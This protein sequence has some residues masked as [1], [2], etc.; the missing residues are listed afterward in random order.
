MR[1]ALHPVLWL[2]PCLLAIVSGAAAPGHAE[3][4]E[5]N[6]VV[7]VT[8][9]PHS[10]HR[11][12]D[13]AENVYA[14]TYRDTYDYADALVILTYESSPDTTFAGHLSA[15]N[16][17]PNFAYQMKL[18]GKPT[19]LWGAAGD[20]AVNELIG[21]TGRWWR[22]QPD[23]GNSND[24]DYEAHHD[25]PGYIFEGYLLFDFFITDDAGAA[26]VDFAVDSSYHV[27]FWE[28]QR[29]PGACDSPVKWSTVTGSA[30]D[31]AYDVDVGPADIGV[32][33]QIERLCTGTS[34][35]PLGLYDCRFLLTEE[36]F[37]Q[38]GEIGGYWQSA[39]VH[40]TIRFE[41]SDMSDA[42]PPTHD[43]GLIAHPPFPNPFAGRTALKFELA[44]A[45]P[46]VFT[47]YD[48][49][50]RLVRSFAPRLW[51]AGE[52]RV[53]WDGRDA[54]GH[55]APAGTYVFRLDIPGGEATFGTAVMIR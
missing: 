53:A 27:L 10:T 44:D 24:A 22:N 6:P 11:W 35:M 5:L 23:T 51:H 45:S 17:K 50:G 38:S 30:A 54:S 16:L 13:I 31:P 26:E 37:H 40:D 3:T 32:Y 34:T 48:L 42:G 41:I 43:V 19:A 14:Q 1:K 36:S 49:A 46:V 33:A 55:P 7:G 47:V 39:L 21:Y 20:D 9:W 29:T 8:C 12:M 15:V 2:A 52:H 4:A 28:H 18:V 25:D